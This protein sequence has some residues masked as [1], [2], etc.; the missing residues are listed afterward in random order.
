MPS[1][2]DGEVPAGQLLAGAMLTVGTSECLGWCELAV[3]KPEEY[4]PL[5]LYPP[6]CACTRARAPTRRRH[7]Y[8][9]GRGYFVRPVFALLNMVFKPVLNVPKLATMLMETM[10]AIRAYSMAVMPD[11]FL[12]KF[13]TR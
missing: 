10:P 5:Y 3:F 1:E 12:R 4:V 9:A 7:F 11:S 13:L 8:E 2:A 6:R